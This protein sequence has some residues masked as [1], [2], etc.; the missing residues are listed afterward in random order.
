MTGLDVKRAADRLAEARR[1]KRARPDDPAA[2]REFRAALDAFE[3]V[4]AAGDIHAGP[5]EVD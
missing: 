1:Q 3:K 5:V 2:Q 4:R